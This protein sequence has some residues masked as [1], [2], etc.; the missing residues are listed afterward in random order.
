MREDLSVVQSVHRISKDAGLAGDH[1][2]AVAPDTDENM[3]FRDVGELHSF[4]KAVVVN[5]YMSVY[6]GD[7]SLIVLTCWK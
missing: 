6:M 4:K 1:I 3:K 7:N 2:I 5:E